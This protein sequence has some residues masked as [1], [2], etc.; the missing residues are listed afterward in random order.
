MVARP[1]IFKLLYLGLRYRT[2]TSVECC[3]FFSKP[4][5][6]FARRDNLLFALIDWVQREERYGKTCANNGDNIVSFE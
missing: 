6:P 4:M 2:S 1:Q 5:N 3:E